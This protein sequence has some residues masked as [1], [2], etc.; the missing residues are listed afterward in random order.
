MTPG[1]W[2]LH[3]PAILI[4]QSPKNLYIGFEAS[5]LQL[6]DNIKNRFSHKHLSTALRIIK[7]QTKE[8]P[9]KHI[10]ASTGQS[11]F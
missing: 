11:S 6:V 1:D 7:R 5:R 8:D 10:E 4:F 3:D 2:I 9:D